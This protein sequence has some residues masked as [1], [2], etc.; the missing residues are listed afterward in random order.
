MPFLAQFLPVSFNN[1]P[2]LSESFSLAYN[3]L[4]GTIPDTVSSWISLTALNLSGNYLSGSLPPKIWSL[5]NL[6]SLDLSH[7]A[8]VGFVPEGTG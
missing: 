6:R 5:T 1:A 4:Q 3:T 2:P 7:N 8:F